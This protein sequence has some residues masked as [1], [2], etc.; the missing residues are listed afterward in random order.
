V[1][2]LADF[3]R[4]AKERSGDA[5][6]SDRAFGELL[7]HRRGGKAIASAVISNARYGKCSDGL[8][9][10]IAEAA[11]VEAGAVLMAARLEREPDAIVRAHLE[12][13]A[14]RVGKVL[15]SVPAKAVNALGAVAVALGM[16]LLPAHDAQAVG[17][18][19]RFR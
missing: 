12:R 7:A 10:A 8:A 17:G 15:A 18:A 19:G 14:V 6:M 2:K 16:F 11:G 13:W 4:V 1:E 3:V 9:I 5:H